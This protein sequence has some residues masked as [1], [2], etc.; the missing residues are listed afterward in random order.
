M[1]PKVSLF[2]PVMYETDRQ[3]SLLP[4]LKGVRGEGNGV[5]Y[6]AP[7]DMPRKELNGPLSILRKH[8]FDLNR[9]AQDAENSGQHAAKRTFGMMSGAL[10]TGLHAASTYGRNPD[11][12]M[13]M[14]VDMSGNPVTAAAFQRGDAQGMSPK[15]TLEDLFD[16][17]FTSQP[18]EPGTLY[19]IGS[20]SKPDDGGKYLSGTDM[21]RRVQN[22]LGDDNLVFEAIN[23]P[24]FSNIGYYRGIGAEPTGATGKSDQPVFTLTKPARRTKKADMGQQSFEGFACGGLAR[25][26]RGK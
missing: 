10:E 14:Q 15:Q 26:R 18:S 23:S 2:K 11:M 20:K 7:A 17:D 9:L 12:R 8:A 6:M 3:V 16:L 1:P 5:Y 19:Y 13:L 25:L 24:D 22:A 21:I 4:P